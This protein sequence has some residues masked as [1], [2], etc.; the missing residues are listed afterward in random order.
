MEGILPAG[1]R[2]E[3]K[4]LV[5]LELLANRRL[6]SDHFYC[7]LDRLAAHRVCRGDGARDRHSRGGERE[8]RGDECVSGAGKSGRHLGAG[9]GRSQRFRGGAV[10]SAA[11]G[12]MFCRGAGGES[13]AGGGGG[14]GVGPC[15][16]LLAWIQRGQGG[17][18]FGGGGV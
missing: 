11:G 2:L 16:Y 6:Q 1:L 5:F 10:G 18:N 17:R 13:G 7:V 4:G 12:E 14:G 3:V 15:L 8:Y 9:A